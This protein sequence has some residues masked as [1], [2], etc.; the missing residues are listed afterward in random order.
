[1]GTECSTHK[2][3]LKARQ[4][5]KFQSKEKAER[6]ALERIEFEPHGRKE[7]IGVFDGETISSD[8]GGLML[9]EVE[10]RA[11]IIEQAAQCF[12]DGRDPAKIEHTVRE[13][14]GQ[15]VYGLALGYEDLNDHND[16][17]HDPLLALLVGKKDPT[18]AGRKRDADKGKAL[19]GA[20]TLNRLELTGA[21]VSA[22]ERYKKISLDLE[23]G[24]LLFARLFLQEHE[25]PP[26]RIVLD[27][28]ATDDELHGGQ[29]GRF[30][31]GYYGHYCYLPLY[32]FCDNAL[33]WAEL[34][35]SNIDP[36]K[37]SVEALEKITGP[38]REKWPGV[39]IVIRADS[40][41]CREYLMSWCEER[42]VC[43]AL[44]MA[45]NSRLKSK[46]RRAMKNA[47]RRY[48]KTGKASRAFCDFSYRT[49]KSWSK[50][51]RVIGKAEY[52]PGKPNER[53][54][55]TNIPLQQFDARRLYEDFYCA[56]GEME[57][58]IKEQQL[59]MFADRTSTET[60]RGNRIRL[61]FSSLA[62]CLMRGLRRIGLRGT[63]MARAQCGTIRERLFKIGARIRITV[64][65]VWISYSQ[66]YPYQSLFKRI[67]YNLRC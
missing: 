56:R 38:I 65:K 42:G 22:G 34:R 14:V 16:L 61:W 60:M 6:K 49:R 3:E 31:H 63:S 59:D 37:G 32:V 10:K 62:Y 8:A 52:I 33:L 43:Y 35:P 23:E 66:S 46:V 7:V 18:G 48:G 17:R 1:M 24:M 30:F 44:G 58:R 54:V 41:F 67:A 25:T 20:S 13:L 29:E 36:A 51:R 15:R 53:F 45:K 5:I 2:I 9:R 40:G 4:G 47:R 50:S 39:E 26:R 21:E 11:R 55:V 27:L 12:A 28:D 64:R 57:N 19:A